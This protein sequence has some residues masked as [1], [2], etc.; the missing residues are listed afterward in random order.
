M[1]SCNTASLSWTCVS[2]VNT[3]KVALLFLRNDMKR[4]TDIGAGREQHRFSACC[5]VRVC[6]GFA[7]CNRVCVT[8]CFV[9]VC[10]CVCDG[11]CV[12]KG[13]YVCV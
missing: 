2:K 5:S 4:V 1:L 6:L 9:C 13:V 11:V 12:C 3:E 10:V 7:V 8:M